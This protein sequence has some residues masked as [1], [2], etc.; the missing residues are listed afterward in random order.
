MPGQRTCVAYWR[1]RPRNRGLL[2]KF[3]LFPRLPKAKE[4][5][6]RRDAETSTR[7]AC[8][9]QSGGPLACIPRGDYISP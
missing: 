2:S 4:R 1:V 6:F 7:N 8:A 9:T 5:L 3:V